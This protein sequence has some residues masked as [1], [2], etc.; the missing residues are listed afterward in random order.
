MEMPPG[1]AGSG[2][3]QQGGALMKSC[4]KGM[5]CPCADSKENNPGS[6]VHS[7][8]RGESGL[9]LMEYMFTSVPA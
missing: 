1:T 9:E 2:R 7:W 5:V 6:Y 4:D 3:S 8:G